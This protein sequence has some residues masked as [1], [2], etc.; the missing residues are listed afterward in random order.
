MAR[1]TVLLLLSALLVGLMA[2][3]AH[4]IGAFGP[5]VEILNPGC[6]FGFATGDVAQDADEN[7]HG[8]VQFQGGACVN[9]VIHYFEGSGGTWTRQQSPYRGLVLAVAQDATGTYLLYFTT[10]Q[11]LRITKRLADGTFTGGRELSSTAGTGALIPQGDVVATGGQWWA[12]WN[13][14]VGP[15][16][17]FAQTE[18]FQAF[19]IGGV[20]RTRQ[21]ITTN[22][23][24]DDQPT[25][26][27]TPGP[28]FPLNLIWARND[29]AQGLSSDP[30]R[31]LGN[32]SG[33]WSSANLATIGSNNLTPDAR[34]VGGTTYVTWWRD[35]R[36]VQADNGGGSFASHTFNTPGQPGPR[37]GFSAGNVYAAWTV[38]AVPARTFVAERVGGAWTGAR[39]SPIVPRDQVLLGIAPVDGSATA[40]NLSITS[41]LY[42]TNES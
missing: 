26:A 21:R 16:G 9:Q 19:T 28:T 34:V 42:A 33:G 41:R 36:I 10:N 22:P 38:A 18:L 24:N 32:A 12:V 2:A 1:R 35:G 5:P 13:E 27:L 40:I 17:E 15:G 8:F 29:G 14:A 30:R 25:L 4:A 3:P 37:I 23:R 31:G 6:S 7:A 39:A 11:R 20:N